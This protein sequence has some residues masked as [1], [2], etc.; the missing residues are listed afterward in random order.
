MMTESA[1][2]MPAPATW[3]QSR[4]PP[5]AGS[6]ACGRAGQGKVTFNARPVACDAPGGKSAPYHAAHFCQEVRSAI[7]KKLGGETAAGRVFRT[8]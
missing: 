2:Q 6:P 4:A 7:G 3:C 5:T 1:A 8:L